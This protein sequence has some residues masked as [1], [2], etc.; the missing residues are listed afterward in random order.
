MLGP[1]RNRRP[2]RRPDQPG[3]WHLSIAS[4]RKL[5]ATSGRS[6]MP[7]AHSHRRANVWQTSCVYTAMVGMTCGLGVPGFSLAPIVTAPIVTGALTGEP[8]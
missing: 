7:F 3:P 5:L 2:S 8:G 6:L 4:I 1:G